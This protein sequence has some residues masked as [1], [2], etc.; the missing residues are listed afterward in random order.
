MKFH[1]YM[2]TGVSQE[3]TAAGPF[4]SRTMLFHRQ[5][6]GR[7]RLLSIPRVSSH[8]YLASGFMKVHWSSETDCS[9]VHHRVY[10]WLPEKAEISYASHSKHSRCHPF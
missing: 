2:C 1:V 9:G 3:G 4:M 8:L 7:S 10:V 6:A 5:K